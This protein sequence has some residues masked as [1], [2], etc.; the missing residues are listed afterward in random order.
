MVT[1]GTDIS[2]LLE[3]WTLT[4]SQYFTLMLRWYIARTVNLFTTDVNGHKPKIPQDKNYFPSIAIQSGSFLFRETEND[5]CSTNSKPNF[6][7]VFV[8]WLFLLI[9]EKLQHGLDRRVKESCFSLWKKV[10]HVA[11]KVFVFSHLLEN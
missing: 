5:V 2:D 7:V 3:T 11:W 10:N 8:S 4:F 1:I 9:L 6:C